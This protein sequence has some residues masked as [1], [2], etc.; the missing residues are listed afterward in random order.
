MGFDFA[1]DFA[2]GYSAMISS[3]RMKNADKP[4]V[5]DTRVVCGTG[6][7]PDKTILN[8]PRFLEEAGYRNLC[9]YMHPPGDPGFEQLQNKARLWQAPLLGVPD[10]GFWDWRVVFELLRICRREQVQIWHGHDYKSN[11]LGLLLRRFW[12]MRLVTTVHGWVKH[13]RRTPLYYRIDRFCL[14]RYERVLCV[15]PDL[16]Q[17]CLAA[18]VPAQRCLLIEN[19]IDVQ[20]FSRRRN[21]EQAKRAQGISPGRLVVGAVG[22]LSPEKGFDLLIQAA[23]HLLKGGIDLELLIVGEGEEQP[24]LQHLIEQLGR[25]DRIRL[26]GYHS[27]LRGLYEAMDVFALS[28]LRE[29]LPNVLLE[30]MALEVPVAATRIAG[31]PRLIAD[32]VNGLLVSPGS[33]EELTRALGELLTRADLRRQLR[34]AGRHTIETRYSF[35]A[36]M[37]R[38]QAVYDDLLGREGRSNRTR[39][40]YLPHLGPAL[41]MQEQGSQQHDQ[42]AGYR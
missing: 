4:V 32:G 14:P 17:Q 35:A 40:G 5:L 13:T 30:A 28:S 34:Q 23:D 3:P 41:L 16:E 39:E 7:G 19:G 24:R 6:G 21:V 12:P 1:T 26:L 2:N 22:R 8:S 9:V 36:R 27:D 15:S 11:A 29:G 42:V 33:I 18:G 31:V 10:R 20:E 38:I 37:K 25:E